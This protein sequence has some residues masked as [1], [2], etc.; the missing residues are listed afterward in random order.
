MSIGCG[1]H[2]QLNNQMQKIYIQV[3]R[4]KRHK[5]YEDI[6]VTIT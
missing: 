6:W 2:L 3:I 4:M 5:K 1:V